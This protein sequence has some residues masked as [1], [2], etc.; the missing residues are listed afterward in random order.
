[1]ASSPIVGLGL[2]SFHPE[3]ARLQLVFSRESPV[4]GVSNS[5]QHL[6]VK[7]T[8]EDGGGYAQNLKPKLPG[9]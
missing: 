5:L 8:P 3:F 4:D 9:A 6:Y 1:M 2:S 7:D